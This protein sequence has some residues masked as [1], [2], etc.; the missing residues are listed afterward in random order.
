MW[1]GK[2]AQWI[3]APVIKPDDLRSIPRTHMVKER[4]NFCHIVLRP[5]YAYIYVQNTHTH[6]VKKEGGREGVKKEVK[7]EGWEGK[8]HKASNMNFKSARFSR[9][10]IHTIRS[11]L[12]L[13]AL[14]SY[15]SEFYFSKTY[16]G[17]SFFKC[18][19]PLVPF[20]EVV[21]ER[22]QQ[23]KFYSFALS[24]PDVSNPFYFYVTFHLRCVLVTVLLLW[25]KKS[26]AR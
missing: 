20:W 11:I 22:S 12:L 21:L 4:T 2:M 13:D 6:N 17:S 24:T 1:A 18:S 10:Y 5:P 14:G 3:K 8:H 23:V 9:S 15:F 25:K 19:Q 7:K 16:S 26:R